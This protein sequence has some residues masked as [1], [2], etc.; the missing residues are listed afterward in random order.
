MFVTQNI[1]T[2][3]KHIN[4]SQRNELANFQTTEDDITN[5]IAEYIFCIVD[6][7]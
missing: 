1:N 2:E 5:N 3:D 6:V 7:N 4:R